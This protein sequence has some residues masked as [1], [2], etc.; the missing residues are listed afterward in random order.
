MS[1][2]LKNALIIDFLDRN[3]IHFNH[4]SKQY[5]NIN[6]TFLCIKQFLNWRLLCVSTVYKKWLNLS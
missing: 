2:L 5:F 1:E 6:C 3:Q 4:I